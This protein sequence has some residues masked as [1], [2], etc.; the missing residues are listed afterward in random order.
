[1]VSRHNRGQQAALESRKQGCMS[2]RK[3]LML[4]L[5]VQS[6]YADFFGGPEVGC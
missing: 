3:H 4:S 2:D 1:M 5:R 6:V